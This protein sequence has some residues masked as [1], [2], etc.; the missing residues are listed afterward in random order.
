MPSDLNVLY[1][2]LDQADRE[3]KTEVA[4]IIAKR[5]NMVKS[6]QMDTSPETGMSG[7][8]KAAVG[9][10]RGMRDLGAGA[11]QK[12]L[13]AGEDMG[14]VPPGQAQKWT[15][16]TNEEIRLFEE[17]MPGIGAESFGR[18]AGWAAP[19]A[20]TGGGLGGVTAIGALEG[21]IM[22]TENPE[23]SE[24]A[25]NAAIGAATAGTIKAAPMAYRGARNLAD[26]RRLRNI[27]P[28]LRAFVEQSGAKVSPDQ[29]NPG[30]VRNTLADAT[31]TG[32]R[33]GKMRDAR[34]A[35]DDLNARYDGGNIQ[36]AFNEGKE[37]ISE[38]ESEYWTQ[39]W[40]ILGDIPVSKPAL[41][42][43]FKTIAN[44]LA[45]RGR[46]KELERLEE[47]WASRP[48]SNR[49]D[50]LHRWRADFGADEQAAWA[51]DG[52]KPAHLKQMYA[53]ITNEIETSLREEVGDEGVDLFQSA[54]DLTKR[55][56]RIEENTGLGKKI[57]QNRKDSETAF[58]RAALGKDP[59]KRQAIKEIIGREG[60][61]S[62]REQVIRQINDAYGEGDPLKAGKEIDKL[63]D[64]INEFF[65]PDEAAMI[66]GLNKFMKS[67]PRTVRD[68]IRSD[69][70]TSTAAAAALGA[71]VT[72]NTAATA[73]GYLALR[74]GM[75]RRDVQ[76]ML[77]KLSKTDQ[78]TRLYQDLLGALN[79]AFAEGAAG[80]AAS[81][82]P[83]I[84]IR[85]GVA[86]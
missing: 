13:M 71:G 53:K 30:A 12:A 1:Q 35:L 61:P 23:W 7:L 22:P 86:Q 79:T 3:G 8:E 21:G 9:F 11:W 32:G 37:R 68:R 75:R 25:Q 19:A 80:A 66:R 58:I 83:N 45:K 51:R 62:V 64:T 69:P 57:R 36:K 77:Q 44:D 10:Q 28:D 59:D 63:M 73:V 76:A 81:Q 24:A 49:V 74:R 20:M 85:D 26:R 6:S 2:D 82:G 50:D 34:A 4:H 41:G 72:F 14:M 60:M 55:N 18:F 33:R 5:I 29:Y 48:A 78:D 65:D 16:E 43:E 27:D 52:L 15:D 39:T 47:L 38:H 56:R 46:W 70:A 40:D 31:I 17:G 54:V 42:A 84:E 67:T